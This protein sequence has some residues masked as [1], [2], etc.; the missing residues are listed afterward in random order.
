[1]NTKKLKTNVKLDKL[2]AK[3]TTKIAKKLKL[4]NVQ[5]VILYDI[6]REGLR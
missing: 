1:M 2:A 6:V 4:N 3:I 5:S